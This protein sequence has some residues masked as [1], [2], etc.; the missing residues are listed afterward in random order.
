MTKIIV[1]G[2]GGDNA[3]DEVLKGCRQA[4]DQWDIQVI[5]SGDE[6]ALRRSAQKLG[7]SLDG[8]EFLQ[9]SQ[10]LT[11]ED[12][13][14]DIR[15][16][17]SDSSMAVGLKALAQG[18]GDAFVSGGNT[19]ALAMGATLYVK[20]MKGVKRAALG[21]VIPC[22]KGCYLLLDAGANAECR[23][24]MLAQF[25]VMG[26]VYMERVMGVKDPGVALVN[27]GTEEHKGTPMHREAYEL[28]SHAPI[29]FL[30]NIEAREIPQGGADV[31]VCDGFTG[32]VILKLTEGLA[33]FLMGKIK[34]VFLRSTLTKLA[35]L[36]LKEGLQ[37]LKKQMDYTEYGGA[38]LM[39]I[40]KP[41]IKAHGSSNA[42]AIKNA[43]RQAKQYVESGAGEEIQ[44][45]L[46]QLEQQAD[47]PAN[48]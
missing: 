17:K 36:L 24:D 15:R 45:R 10:V 7:I 21:T 33:Q 42:K 23:P 14:A 25:G 38:P 11:M 20:R 2:F 9:A 46:N 35:A 13:P 27:V 44:A 47:S 4:A 3:P 22:D 43:L 12:D 8:M 30:G 31:C 16:A 39:G 29:R 40:A 26:S 34:G 37:D 28:L 6:Q 1:D 48:V 18:K 32:N 5:L 41:V 19:G